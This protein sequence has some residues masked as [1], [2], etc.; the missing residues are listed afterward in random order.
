MAADKKDKP[1]LDKVAELAGVSSATVD[2]VLNERGGVSPKTATRVLDAA[3]SLGIGRILPSPYSRLFRIKFVMPSSSTPLFYRLKRAFEAQ[4]SQTSNTLIID[5]V[6]LDLEN[7]S[8]LPEAFAKGDADAIVAFVPETN[9]AIEAIAAATSAGIPIVTLCS[10]LPT[11]PRLAYVGI[12]H[13]RAGRAAGFLMA[14]MSKKERFIAVCSDLTFR[15]ESA[16]IGGFRDAL[17]E[18]LGRSPTLEVL[19]GSAWPDKVCDPRVSG[20]YF[21][22]WDGNLSEDIRRWTDASPLVIAHDLGDKEKLLMKQGH[23]AIAIDQ[24]PEEQAARSLSILLERLGI[25]QAWEKT[26]SVP[27]TIHTSHN[28]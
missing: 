14:Q 6:W 12:D 21:A 23:I 4:I 8:D 5:R 17:S 2:R 20:L 11:T 13:Y 3:K 15:A 16:R 24:N 25:E 10:D 27:F 26:G 1:R 19:E 22:G 28:I 9:S 18:E 7:S